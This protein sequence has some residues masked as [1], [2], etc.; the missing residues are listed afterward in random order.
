MGSD[1]RLLGA[2][3]I[4]EFA[5]AIAA[6]G[7]AG[8]SKALLIALRGIAPVDHLTLLT[9]QPESGLHI[10]GVASLADDAVARS[11]T[12]DFVARDYVYD[13][14]FDELQRTTRSRRILIRRHEFSRLEHKPYQSRFYTSVGIV[15]KLAFIWRNPEAGY[16]VNLYRT[17]RSGPYHADEQRRLGILAR[18]IASVVRLHGQR[19]H[20]EAKLRDGD[21]TTVAEHLISLLGP[22]L[23]PREQSVL[24]RIL[25]GLSAEGIALEL[26]L[27]ASS[28]ITFRKRA[29]RKLGISTQAELF[30]CSLGVLPVFARTQA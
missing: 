13:P 15:D 19:Q 11:L 18:L 12:R 16:Y 25:L 23:A 2:T 9:F 28:V 30:R 5:E 20:L 10:L 1:E 26:G 4:N 29:Y 7:T 22:K 8:F 27:K 3:E 21:K 17:L 24:A 14:N 6:I